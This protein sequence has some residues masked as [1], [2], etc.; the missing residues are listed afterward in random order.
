M[1]GASVEDIWQPYSEPILITSDDLQ[2][3]QNTNSKMM[4]ARINI[5]LTDADSI[6][7]NITNLI[8][9]D[10]D[11]AKTFLTA[12]RAEEHASGRYLL[13]YILRQWDSYLDLSQIEVKR[14]NN[15]RKPY[16]SW[17]E[18]TYQG[19][20]LPEFSISH[21]NGLAMIALCD[22]EYVV[23][24]DLEPLN[25]ERSE[26]LMEFVS[27]GE[28]L[29]HLRN[30]WMANSKHGT[31]ILNHVWTIKE[32]CMKSLG[33]GM[34][35]NPI[36]IKIPGNIMKN[37]P[38]EKSN[39]QLEYLDE[40][41]AVFNSTLICNIKYSIS[42]SIRAKRISERPILNQAEQEMYDSL[43]SSMDIGCSTN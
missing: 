17:I 6:V 16:I 1:R 5:R 12:K 18:G 29:Q 2:V 10:N 30:N 23:G 33:T 22:N 3:T 37:F 28:E 36:H 8:F 14:E 31:Q 19:K 13:Q 41:I 35:I 15:T 4:F 25:E 43:Q 20:K 34:G 38:I 39:F 21:S 40:S 9:V 27:A 11:E 32:S 26:N 24:L 7:P 42:I